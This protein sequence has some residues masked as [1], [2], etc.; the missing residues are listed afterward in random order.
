MCGCWR[1]EQK[2]G[3]PKASTAM[4][5]LLRFGRL[6]EVK[7]GCEQLAVKTSTTVRIGPDE[8]AG[9]PPACAERMGRIREVNPGPSPGL[10]PLSCSVHTLPRLT[11]VTLTLLCFESAATV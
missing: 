4:L 11:G 3:S 6:Q 9:T 10:G 1:T 7:F 8:T 5:V 2:L